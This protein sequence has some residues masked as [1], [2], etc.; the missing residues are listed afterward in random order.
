MA[1]MDYTLSVPGSW[2]KAKK[3]FVEMSCFLMSIG[4]EYV[5]ISPEI[6][7]SSYCNRKF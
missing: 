5:A 2:V 1:G 6:I 4:V 7:I 3:A